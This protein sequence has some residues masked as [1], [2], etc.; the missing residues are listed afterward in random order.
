M[1]LLLTN[2]SFSK[3][4]YEMILSELIVNA[5]WTET[6]TLN[7]YELKCNTSNLYITGKN[8]Y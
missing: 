2:K 5:N 3:R 7:N 8:I 6:I 1:G 4:P